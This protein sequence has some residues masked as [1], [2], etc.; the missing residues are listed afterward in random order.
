MIT[1]SFGPAM[2]GRVVLRCDGPKCRPRRRSGAGHW[3]ARKAR[4]L[5]A[6]YGWKSSGRRD[7][8]EGCAGTAYVPTGRGAEV[9]RE[10]E[11]VLADWRAS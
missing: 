5:A 3:R 6:E 2:L 10:A 4:A 7:L 1:R 11:R 8:C 9:L